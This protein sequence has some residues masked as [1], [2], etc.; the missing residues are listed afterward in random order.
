M[1]IIEKLLHY[2]NPKNLFKKPNPENKGN[3]NLF[4]MHGINRISILMFL[5]AIIV[6]IIKYIN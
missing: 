2:L 4:L 3:V 5:I 1:M 6:I